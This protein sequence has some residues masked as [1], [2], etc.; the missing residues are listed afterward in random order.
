MATKKAAASSKKP[1][2]ASSKK[3]A[4]A[5]PSGNTAAANTAA[6]VITHHGMIAFDL[7]TSYA[8]ASGTANW[9][10]TPIEWPGVPGPPP[11]GQILIT[12]DQPIKGPY[13][14]MVSAC[15]SP[16]APMLAANYGEQS[17]TGFVVILFNTVGDQSYTS[18]RN[19]NFSFIIVQ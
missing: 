12:F 8:R 6:P 4:A 2:A 11:V 9:S 15:R 1:A 17:P 7:A 10:V 13:T 5:A 19:G 16:D 14:V 3:A 18:V